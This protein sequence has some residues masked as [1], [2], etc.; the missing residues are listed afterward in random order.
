MN[1]NNGMLPE[2]QDPQFEKLITLLRQ[3]DLNPPVIDPSEHEK[4]ITNV[5]ARLFP[6]DTEVAQ[7]ELREP[8]F[9]PSKPKSQRTRQRRI[10]RL[11]NVMAAVLVVTL[12]MSSALL[13]FGPWS[14]LQRDRTLTGS[15]IGQVG[16]P[17][18]FYTG[19]YNGF[20]ISLSITP[21]P[22]FLGELLETRLSV[23]NHT[24][25][26]YWLYPSDSMCEI[27]KTTTT[28]GGSP[29]TTD[30]QR[31]LTGFPEILLRCNSPFVPGPGHG[32]KLPANQ[33]LTI[34]QY[35]QL[36][37]S[38]QVTLTAQVAFLKGT[39]AFRQNG[40][41]A[42]PEATTLQIAVNPL[43]SSD[44]RFSI[45]E[46][47]MQVAVNVPL[48]AHEHL[49]SETLYACGLGSN[50]YETG[51]GVGNVDR[52]VSQPTITLQAPQCTSSMP[53]RLWWWVYVV[54]APGFELISGK[55]R[56]Q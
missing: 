28:G 5:R 34:K 1:S 32:I 48:G 18:T 46:Q 37:R 9:F 52:K 23:T 26:T 51:G 33:T 42:A 19:T 7:A 55:V 40:I 11:I 27:L 50:V 54:G 25:T 38:G 8:G 17:V 2:E 53:V 30:V 12:L 36:T 43:V 44:R 49:F 4:I 14:P 20:G 16:M 41:G 39:N 6:T 45:T 22:Y 31:N 13:L 10:V 3:A 47:K 21:G 29:Y 35:L 15:P 24:H 56:V